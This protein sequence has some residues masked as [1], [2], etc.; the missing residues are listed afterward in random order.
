MGDD[1][2]R[3]VRRGLDR[4]SLS[5]FDLSHQSVCE[6]FHPAVDFSV[7]KLVSFRLSYN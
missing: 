2:D 6:S 7:V 5:G 3:Y 1:F 4:H